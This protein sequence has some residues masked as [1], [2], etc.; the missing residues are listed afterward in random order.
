MT[1]T[2]ARASGQCHCGAIRYTMPTTVAHHAVCHCQD[3]R[4]HSGAP[5]VGWALVGQSELDVTGA[6]QIYASSEQGRRHFCGTCGTGLFYTNDAV[7]PDQIDVQ[8]ATLDDPDLIPAQAQIQTA[9]RIGWMEK[10]GSLPS[11]ER[12]PAMD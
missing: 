10:L 2:P 8:T 4:R 11:F 3:C 9:E 1:D 6:P 7:F 5:L 12:Y